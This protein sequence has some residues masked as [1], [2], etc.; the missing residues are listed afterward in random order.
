VGRLVDEAQGL[1]PRA[2]VSV[3]PHGGRAREEQA[4]GRG[5][6]QRRE[7]G[8]RVRRAEGAVGTVRREHVH[9][10][11]D[12]VPRHADGIPGEELLDLDDVGDERLLH[13]WDGNL[14]L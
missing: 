2:G 8:Q 13:R 12:V 1:H 14:V 6:H 3:E 4:L 11:V 9:D 10:G 5:A 7:V